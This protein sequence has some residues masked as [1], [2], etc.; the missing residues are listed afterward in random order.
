MWR[1]PPME[2]RGER[3]VADRSSRF[4]PSRVEAAAGL[5]YEYVADNEACA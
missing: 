4:D 3:V 5:F 1:A 2:A